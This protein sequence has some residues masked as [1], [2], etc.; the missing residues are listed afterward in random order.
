MKKRNM[1]I[2]IVGTGTIGESLARELSK[3]GCEVTI[4]DTDEEVLSSISNS[5][6]VIGYKG[7]GASYNTLSDLNAE[8]AD[9]LIAVTNSDEINLLSCFTAH[10]LGTK[11]T[12][13]RIRDVDYASRNDF[14][15][16]ELGISLIINPDFATA[17]EVFRTIRFPAA[18]RIEL[19]AG[20]RAELVE[21]TVREDSPIAGSKLM[22]AG[23]YFDGELLI[24]AIVRDGEAFVPKG[25]TI[26]RAKD[27]LYL[28]GT[29]AGFRSSFKKLKYP[30]K[31]L[32]NV[33]IAG[34]D[35][36]T[37]YLAELLGKHG[38]KVTVVDRD[39]DFCFDMAQKLPKAAVMCEDSLKYLDS[40]S[41]SDISHTD[42]FISITDDDEYNLIAAM[43]AE[44]LGFP[45]IVTRV[46][47]K[48]RTKVLH[49]DSS[50]GVI[51]REDVA[52]DRILG[53]TRAVLNVGENDAVESLY[54]L[55]DGRLEFMEFRVSDSDKNTGEML[56]NVKLKK[57][58]L[59]A[60]IIRKG[61]MII[62]HGD[63]M[64]EA[65]DVALVASVDHQLSELGDIYE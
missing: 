45:K 53:Y 55:V 32:T 21:L 60:G 29:E 15:R 3:D 37:F 36:V 24:C 40:M 42:A 52:S 20:G 48:T 54:R 2:F 8:W 44:T 17:N 58:T 56:K 41:E 1:R 33:M 57:N 50:I 64:L 22:D 62:P 25:D 12:I 35:R 61:H 19:F 4:I 23:N 16:D 63:D 5:T 38:A 9:V 59:L 31:P 10:K 49:P 14:Y 39:R 18:T 7:N 11:H 27:I 28:T 51:S 47:A 26:I 43:Y 34:N 6:D 46:A 65:G 13:A 30:I